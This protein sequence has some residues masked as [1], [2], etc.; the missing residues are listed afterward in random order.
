MGLV[1]VDIPRIVEN[2][3]TAIYALRVLDR[4]ESL[5]P[6]DG[7]HEG[8]RTRLVGVG[9]SW[10]LYDQL[11]PDLKSMWC[12]SID[13]VHAQ[14][15]EMQ[16][17]DFRIA[18]RRLSLLLND[19]DTEILDCDYMTRYT[20]ES[21][22]DWVAQCHIEKPDFVP[23]GPQFWAGR[24]GFQAF[25]GERRIEM[26]GAAPEEDPP[27][28]SE[29]GKQHLD[30]TYLPKE[31]AVELDISDKSLSTYAKAA[32]VDTPGRGQRNHRYSETDREAICRHIM[33]SGGAPEPVS[34]ARS[35]VDEIER[36]RKQTEMKPKDRN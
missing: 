10:E 22:W 5:Y 36:N 4:V 3:R 18:I 19:G 11:E 28:A 25:A 31:L 26:L 6:E 32:G 20:L 13:D 24:A 23:G 15:F 1:P 34:L 7:L 8:W 16:W 14:I 12:T 21:V 2:L 35:I 33:A 30:P 27:Q 17:K 29:F 9:I